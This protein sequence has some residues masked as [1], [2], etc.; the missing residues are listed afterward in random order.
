ME[1]ADSYLYQELLEKRQ[2]LQNFRASLSPALQKRLNDYEWTLIPDGGQ[3]GMLLLTLRL[4]RRISLGDPFLVELAEQTQ[5][6]R[7]AVD[8][9][10]FSGEAREPLRVLNQT[11]L[12]QRWRRHEAP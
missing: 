5:R 9:T 2:Q 12:D 4:P 8:F 11:L 1:L 7:G 3:N 6:V 10:L